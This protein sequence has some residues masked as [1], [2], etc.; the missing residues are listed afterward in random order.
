MSSNNK[1]IDDENND[2]VEAM[3]EFLLKVA[4][5]TQNSTK[6]WFDLNDMKKR[7][8]PYSKELQITKFMKEYGQHF[9]CLTSSFSLHVKFFSDETK[10]QQLVEHVRVKH[11][12]LLTRYDPDHLPC[13][14]LLQDLEEEK[15]EELLI[16]NCHN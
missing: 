12:K 4:Y 6:M 11:K 9:G 16:K 7:W 1:Y 8:R 10:F 3:A 13:A 15:E 2:L 14:F 5:L